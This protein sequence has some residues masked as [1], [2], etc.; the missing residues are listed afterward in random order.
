[1]AGGPREGQHSDDKSLRLVQGPSADYRELAADVVCFANGAG[2]VLRIG[3]EDGEDAPPA[4]QRGSVALLEQIRKRVLELTVNVQVAP[5]IVTAG[6]GGEYIALRV[7]RAVGVA[8]TS[9]G[10]YFLRVGD[11]CRPVLGDDVLRLANERPATPWEAMTGLGI[12]RERAD[13]DQTGSLVGRLRASERV[14]DSVKEKGDEETLV[15]YGLVRDG[16]LTHLGVLLVGRR[17]DRERL[18]TAPIVQAIK[19]DE[20][21]TKVAKHL[22][23]DLS[24][25]PVDLVDAVWTTVPDFRES[26]EIPEGLFRTNIPAY[27]E[28]VVRE[29]LVNAL[30]HRPYTQRGDIFLNLRPDHLEVV[31]VGRLPLGVT[32]KNILHVTVRRNDGL[33]RIF[34]DIGLMEREGSG[35]DLMYDRLL[36]AGKAVPEVREEGDAV[37]VVVP[38]RVLHPKVVRLIDDVERT[39]QLRPRERIVLGLLAPTE[40]MSAKELARR[41]ELDDLVMLRGWLSRLLESGVVEQTGKTRA[42]RYFVSPALL[43]GVG[44]DR[45]T[46]LKRIEPH[47]LKALIVEDLRRYPS[48]SS[49]D[50]QRRAAPEVPLRTLRRALGD[51]M[52]RGVV[53][54]EGERRWRRYSLA[55]NGQEGSGGRKAGR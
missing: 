15:H 30:V 48:S 46:T 43:R 51:L 18:G 29:L 53:E 54:A 50:I 3:I 52:D 19:Y 11:H 39:H 7:P 23:D 12:V 35:Y 22:W 10:K 42:T 31:N 38:R 55:P 5:E 37:H 28:A 24:L 4:D 21:G 16:L 9:D 45:K 47:R 41:L 32:P 14:K 1:M 49:K 40:G 34:H 36:S 6:N 33:A 17:E 20:G 2:G 44:L 13:P 25:S 26:Y 27:D 8:S